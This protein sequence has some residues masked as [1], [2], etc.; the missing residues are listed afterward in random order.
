MEQKR[1]W[2]ERPIHPAL[3][4]LTNEIVL[5]AIVILLAI[6]TR[7]YMLGMA[8]AFLLDRLQPDWKDTA[9]RDGVFLEDLLRQAVEE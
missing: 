4:N 6:V 2:L 3:P 5:F 8:E 9:L 7:F 1:N